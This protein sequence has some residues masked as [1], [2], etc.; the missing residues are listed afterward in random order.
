MI[1]QINNISM[2]WWGW[3]SQ[4]FWQ[5]GLLIILVACIDTLIKK[6][7]WPQLRYALWLLVLLKLVIP[8]SYSMPGSLT[9]RLRP[10]TNRI[11]SSM[12]EKSEAAAENFYAP[13]IIDTDVSVP[14]VVSESGVTVTSPVPEPAFENNAESASMVEPE[15]TIS[16]IWQSYAM[17]I[18]LFGMVVLGGWLAVRLHGLRMNRSFKRAARQIPESF[19]ILMLR[20]AQRLRLS[21]LPD[22]VVTDK[23]ICTAVFGLLRPT[24]LIPKNYIK[25]LTRKDVEHM[26]LH[27]LAHVKRGDTIVHGLY[28]ILQI[29]YWFNPLLWLA[30][31]QLHHLRELC[32]DATVAKLLRNRTSEYRETI[33]DIARRYLTRPVEPGL[34]LL[35]LFEDSNK[36]LVRLNWLEKESWRYPKMKNLTVIITVV[37]MLSF[38]LPMALAE[39]EPTAADRITSSEKSE[40]IVSQSTDKNEIEEEIEVETEQELYEQLTVDLEALDVQLNEFK[41][42]K[43]NL[44][45]EKQSGLSAVASAKQKLAKLKDIQKMMT[46]IQN[47]AEII[48]QMVGDNVHYSWKVDPNGAEFKQW[49][50]Q[51]QNW[52]ENAQMKQWRKEMEQWK[53]EMMVWRKELQSSAG[54]R[55]PAAFITEKM[56]EMPALPS[57]PKMFDMPPMPPIPEGAIISVDSVAPV[58][59]RPSKVSDDAVP[60]VSSPAAL[61]APAAVPSTPP[62]IVQPPDRNIKITR[63]D[64]QYVAETKMDFTSKVKPNAKI[65]IR[66]SVGGIVLNP[67]KDDKCSMVAVIKAKADTEEKA[68]RNVEKISMNTHSSDEEFYLKPVKSGDDNWNNLSVDLIVTIPA[69]TRPD[70]STNVGNIILNNINGQIKGVANVGS[71]KSV[72]TSGD[73]N[74]S[75]KVGSIDFTVPKDFSARLVA[76]TQNGSIKSDLPMDIQKKNFIA[77][78][79]SAVYGDG[80]DNI[81]LSTQVGSIKISSQ[82]SSDKA[83]VEP[84]SQV[85][86]SGDT[87]GPAVSRLLSSVNLPESA[88][89]VKAINEKSEGDRQVIERIETTALPLSPGSAL[90]V[91]NE[92]GSIT[93]TGSDTDECRIV[94]SFTIKA[95]TL[96]AAKELSKKVSLEMSPVSGGL[97]VKVV[98]PDN[99]PRN[100]SSRVDMKIAVPRNTNLTLHNED[101]DIEVANLNGNIKV[102]LED[103]DIDCEDIVGDIN[104]NLEDGNIGIKKSRMA[105]CRIRLEDGT[106]QCDDVTGNFDVHLEDGKVTVNYLDGVSD[107]FTFDVSGE[108]G[109]VIISKGVFTQCKVRM[110]SGTIEC[111]KVGGSLD[112]VME[113]GKVIVNY[114]DDVPESCAVDVKLEEGSIELSAPAKMFPEDAPA[115]AKKKDEGAEWK[116]KTGDR[117]VNLSVDEGSIKVNKR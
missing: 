67:G 49:K 48:E 80:K 113:E 102:G 99:T 54:M 40:T 65:I 23:V 106:V 50:M 33:I 85:T 30:R 71:I 75:T 64:D 8:P 4:M 77:S 103:G 34:G 47:P 10:V 114:A 92:D 25:N 88:R 9:G 100:H 79:V 24:L 28:M 116:T 29:A 93:V 112:F 53:K 56:S 63:E 3:M 46:M 111:E 82:G 57:M 61:E 69:G 14:A 76:K 41:E 22:V 115:T 20:C 26:L 78:E 52:Q 97:S 89:N 38:V 86:S 5:V 44:S 6:W 27:E 15:P 73:V 101:G 11:V 43:N 39:S 66:N 104:L 42:Q 37:L 17:A 74:L 55:N 1:E 94:S 95:P 16:F 108:D 12:T 7:A 32:C 70:I 18:W 21:R 117:A 72:G 35:G 109:K 59:V 68:R 58:A 105:N 87:A 62:S 19:E 107:K 91:S 51:M 81:V 45:Q 90:N 110:E 13:F 84:V 83:D 60:V 96:E 2:S 36:L 98:Q 31:R